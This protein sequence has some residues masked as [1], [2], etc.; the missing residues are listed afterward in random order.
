M[1][2][3][4][5]V[6]GPRSFT[7]KTIVPGG[8]TIVKNI[9][10]LM[11]RQ[12]ALASAGLCSRR[13]TVARIQMPPTAGVRTLWA[14]VAAAAQAVAPG[15]RLSLPIQTVKPTGPHTEPSGSRPRC[16][17]T[18]TSPLVP[19]RRRSSRPYCA[20]SSQD[21]RHRHT[22]RITTRTSQCWWYWGI[23][24]LASSDSQ[25]PLHHAQLLHE[26]SSRSSIGHRRPG[27]EVSKNTN[28]VGSH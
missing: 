9:D 22:L 15:S 13:S 6:H 7:H 3:R 21:A 26:I 8:R 11:L 17:S 19:R 27:A 1:S 10:A 20:G 18:R 23:A 25:Q 28:G 14:H 2:L 12:Y 5:F 4:L 16:R 24:R